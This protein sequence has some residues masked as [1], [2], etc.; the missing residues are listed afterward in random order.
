MRLQ[1]E[2]RRS[3]AV[4]VA[5]GG[6]G[7]DDGDEKTFSTSS[8]P[9][10]STARFSFLVQQ[11]NGTLSKSMAE[12]EAQFLV[13]VARNEAAGKKETKG[14]AVSLSSTMPKS[15]VFAAAALA[16][17]HVGLVALAVA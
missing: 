4:T 3:C 16:A 10:S 1:E 15:G 12:L 9:S 14:R 8:S 13:F 2:E 17:S 7:G 5:V 11:C 6:G